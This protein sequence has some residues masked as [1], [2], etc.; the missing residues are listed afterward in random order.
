MPFKDVK[1][2]PNQFT[3]NIEELAESIQQIFKNFIPIGK[4]TFISNESKNHQSSDFAKGILEISHVKISKNHTE[5]SL[6][7]EITPL[8]IQEN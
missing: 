4:M 6:T 5:R 7:R 8:Q 1:N 3:D 2:L